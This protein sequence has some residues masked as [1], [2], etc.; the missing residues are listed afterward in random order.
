MLRYLDDW[1]V[2]ASSQTNAL[3]A[4]DMVLS[5]CRDLGFLVNLA[6]SHLVPAR[7]ATYL[8]MT[9]AT[10]TWRAFPSQERVSALLTQIDEFLS[11]R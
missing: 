10:P 9:I 2:L 1:L 7:S 8:G 6:K 4:R 3:W 5:H 11:Y